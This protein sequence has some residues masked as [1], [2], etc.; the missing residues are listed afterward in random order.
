M[1]TI[2]HTIFK[3]LANNKPSSV[4]TRKDIQKAIWVAQGN[5]IET[6]V[7]RQGYYGINIQS[8]VN[9]E[10]LLERIGRGTYVLSDNGFKFGN[11]TYEEGVKL[12]R[13]INQ[14]RLERR[15]KIRWE[16][17][18]QPHIKHAENFQHFVGKTIVKVRYA[19]PIECSEL[20]WNKSPIVFQMS[21]GTVM[22]P[23]CD[24]EGNDGGALAFVKDGNWDVA[25]TI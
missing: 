3:A 22:Y 7:L 4:F 5:D 23:Q 11:G 20:G 6:F 18:N 12:I 17:M 25:Y 15:R 24:D 9:D 19:T 14:D 21:D 8:W 13:K 1:K 2:K 16:R 10:K